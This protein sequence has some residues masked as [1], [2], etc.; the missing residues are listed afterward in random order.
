MLE[1]WPKESQ[2]YWMGKFRQITK[3]QIQNKTSPIFFWNS[4]KHPQK[5]IVKRLKV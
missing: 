1:T 2:L 4:F 5:I 3:L